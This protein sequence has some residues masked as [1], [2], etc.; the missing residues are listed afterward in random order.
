MMGWSELQA[1]L[2]ALVERHK[3][4]TEH[5]IWS[6][7]EPALLAEIE[8]T[9]RA[10]MLDLLEATVPIQQQEAAKRLYNTLQRDGV[11]R[12][13]NICEEMEKRFLERYALVPLQN[14]T[15][16]EQARMLAALTAEPTIVKG[17]SA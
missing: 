2:M 17:G 10:Q 8:R 16:D 5:P 4:D 15:T 14:I 6:V 1:Q 11:R 9:T 3:T 12:I 13:R 7:F